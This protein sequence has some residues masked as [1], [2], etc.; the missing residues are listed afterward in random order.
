[1][2][3]RTDEFLDVRRRALIAF[4]GPSAWLSMPPIARTGRLSMEVWTA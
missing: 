2:A 1:M 4:A 3:D